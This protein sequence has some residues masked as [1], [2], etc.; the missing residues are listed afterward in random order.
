M[1]TPLRSA[2]RRSSVSF[3][4][5]AGTL[6]PTPGRLI[7]LLLLTGLADDHFSDHV[8]QGD[9][10]CAQ[11]YPTVV[12]QDHVSGPDILGQSLVRRRTPLD[13]ALD[14]VD[15]DREHS[16]DVQLFLAV[17]EPAEPDLGALKVGQYT[18]RAPGVV[19]PLPARY[20]GSSGGRHSRRGSC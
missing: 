14:V 18:D 10:G 6:T 1:S 19:L 16:A 17:G 9:L 4:L 11:S 13:R 2:Q 3:S 12:D 20:A 7:P 5:I 15:G 8:G